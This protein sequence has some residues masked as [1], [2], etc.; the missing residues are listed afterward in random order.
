MLPLNIVRQLVLLELCKKDAM[1]IKATTA[2][3]IKE[4]YGDVVAMKTD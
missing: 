3:H 1:V 4:Y 2:H